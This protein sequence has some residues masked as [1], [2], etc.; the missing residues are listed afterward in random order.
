MNAR[1]TLKSASLAAVLSVVGGISCSSSQEQPVAGGAYFEMQN[2]RNVTTMP[3]PGACLDIGQ[4]YT[5][6]IK[7]EN[8]QLKL[9]V[10]GADDARVTCRFDGS[11][12][13]LAVSNSVA[14]FNTSGTIAGGKSTDAYVQVQTA[15]GNLYKTLTKKCSITFDAPEEGKIGGQVSCDEITLISANNACGLSP[16]GSSPSYFKFSNCKGF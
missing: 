13:D 8:G 12:F 1:L 6:A 14:S 15:N 5:V 16:P 2:A 9:I 10:D 3:P 7:G 11:R 4:K